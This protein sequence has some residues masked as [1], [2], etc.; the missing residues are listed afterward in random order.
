MKYISLLT[1]LISNLLSAQSS[2]SLIALIPVQNPG[3]QAVLRKVNAMQERQIQALQWPEPSVGISAVAL[4]FPNTSMLP[5][6]TL[7]VMQPIPWKGT[8]LLK[9]QIARSETTTLLEEA[10]LLKLEL[11]FQLRQAYWQLFELK[12]TTSVLHETLALL[13]IVEQLAQSNFESGKGTLPD[14][15]AIQ[16]QKQ[17]LQAQIQLKEN[18]RRIPLATINLILGRLPA[19]DVAVQQEATLATMALS[20]ETL[21][22]LAQQTHPALALLDINQEASRQ[23]QQL[24]TLEGK[25]QLSVGLDYAVM[26]RQAGEPTASGRDMWM[27]QLGIRIP[28]FRET[29]H[30]RHRE[31]QFL[32]ESLQLQQDE[33]RNQI[34]TDIE[35]ALANFTNAAISYAL[36]QNQYPLLLSALE[37]AREQ[38]GANGTGLSTLL[39]YEIQLLELK[40]QKISAITESHLASAQLERQL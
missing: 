13:D 2:D 14:I 6:T 15:L 18:A 28:L 21:F 30:S 36:V 25:P 8:R 3:L 24:N 33:T 35:K 29:Y 16:L 34:Q 12:Q 23:R 9:N 26:R 1:L 4:P 7:G 10:A 39:Q 19:E 32:Q 17:A 11:R 20:T 31:E 40:M 22:S 27:P 37:I 5:T 38:F